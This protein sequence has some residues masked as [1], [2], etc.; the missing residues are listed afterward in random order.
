M[1]DIPTI[2]SKSPGSVA[3]GI[4]VMTARR[5]F[6]RHWADRAPVLELFESLAAAAAEEDAQGGD[7]R[8]AFRPHLSPGALEQG[9]AGGSLMRVWLASPIVR[10]RFTHGWSSPACRHIITH[11]RA[12]YAAIAMES[13]SRGARSRGRRATQH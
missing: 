9:L 1:Y 12:A 11:A 8:T 3:Q 6:R 10:L 5:Y 4:Q 13:S 2:I 7:R